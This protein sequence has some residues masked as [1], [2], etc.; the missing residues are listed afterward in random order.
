VALIL[1]VP[2]L[3]RRSISAMKTGTPW[4]NHVEQYEGQTP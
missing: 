1:D 3:V 2:Q 4:S